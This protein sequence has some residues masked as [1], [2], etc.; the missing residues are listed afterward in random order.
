[1]IQDGH[2]RK[3]S[4]PVTANVG[5]TVVVASVEGA[6]IYIH[7]LIGDLAAAGD[8]TIKSGSTTLA[9]F[10]LDA[11]QGITEQDNDGGSNVPHFE[12]KPG[13]D[14]ILTVTGGTFKGGCQYSLRY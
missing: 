4:I 3:T 12:C 14:F 6:W 2:T 10:S 8:L 13:D 11:G 9:H 7:E 5:D 1:M